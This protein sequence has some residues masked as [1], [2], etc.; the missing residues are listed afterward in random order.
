V[1]LPSCV[2]IEKNF[3]HKFEYYDG[4]A[5]NDDPQEPTGS[6]LFSIEVVENME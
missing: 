5:V 4:M 1:R 2:E 6:S 3:S